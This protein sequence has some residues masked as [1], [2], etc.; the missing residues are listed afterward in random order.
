M[1]RLSKLYQAMET[2]A[3]E[4]LELSVSAITAY[5]LIKMVNERLSEFAGFDFGLEEREDIDRAFII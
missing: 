4:G 1:S 5:Y 3:S 2:L